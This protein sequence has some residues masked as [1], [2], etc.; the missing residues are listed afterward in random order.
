MLIGLTGNF[1]CGKSL[2]LNFMWHYGV[3][4]ISADDIVS[5]LLKVDAVK[6]ELVSVLG[7]VLDNKGDI[8]KKKMA[9]IIFNDTIL[10]KK[11]EAIIHPKVM[12]RIR[13]TCADNPGEM[14]AA[15]IPLLF[16]AGLEGEMDKTITVT[17]KPE[18]IKMRL[19]KKGFKEAEI[20][21]RQKAQLPQEAK[22]KRSDFVIDNSL[23]SKE[24]QM[25]LKNIMSKIKE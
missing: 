25:H 6:S 20:K 23:S 19:E 16:E 17:C 4:T 1:G 14:V 8:D 21:L 2:I 5:E 18:I 9:E 13:Q 12:E 22:A 15:E 10:R 3:V 24:T 7:A 11:V